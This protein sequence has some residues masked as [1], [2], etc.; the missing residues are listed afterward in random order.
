M[1]SKSSCD[2]AYE[3]RVKLG[4]HLWDRTW[5]NSS[6][7]SCP[8]LRLDTVVRWCPWRGALNCTTFVRSFC[9]THCRSRCHWWSCTIWTVGASQCRSIH[10]PES[11]I[12]FSRTVWRRFVR[13]LHI[14]CKNSLYY[15]SGFFLCVFQKTQWKKNSIFSRKLNFFRKL[16]QNLAKNWNLRNF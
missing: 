15:Y 9:T 7:R 1:P 13:L 16:N 11:P 3:K 14:M 5:A 2:V 4:V 6:T 12:A 8:S 10:S